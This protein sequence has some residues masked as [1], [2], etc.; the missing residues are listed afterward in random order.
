MRAALERLI[1]PARANT[2]GGG[3]PSRWRPFLIAL[4]ALVVS[5]AVLRWLLSDEVIATLAQALEHARLWQLAVA[6]ALFPMIPA[7]RAWRYT[8]LATGRLEAPGWAMF[9]VTARQDLLNFILPLRLGEL[10]FLVLMKRAFGSSYLQS[11]GVLVI[12]RLLDLG[13]ISTILLFGGAY[14]IDPEAIGWSRPVLLVA[15]AAAL[16]LPVVGVEILALARR[17]AARLPRLSMLDTLFFASTMVRAPGKRAAAM[18]I[19][20]SLWAW[21][22]LMV[23]IAATAV[24]DGL[25]FISLT[26]GFAA[27]VFTIG[28][29]AAHIAGIGAPQAAQATVLNLAGLAWEPAVVAALI[30]NGVML[31][32]IIVVGV[33]TFV[34]PARPEVVEEVVPGPSGDGGLGAMRPVS[35]RS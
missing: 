6:L 21:Q 28:I 35:D 34:L 26:V 17:F 27:S 18:A 25:H 1:A 13:M 8:L 4:V 33:A 19:T 10:S 3:R 12:A 16:A 24:I 30:C 29:P 14:V 20:A 23:Y 15:G 22:A 9:R 5:V 7:L 31:T 32:G 11:L 2:N